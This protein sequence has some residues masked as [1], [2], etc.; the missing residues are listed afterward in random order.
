MNIVSL[1]LSFRS[2][3]IV[4]VVS[5]VAIASTLVTTQSS[6]YGFSGNGSGTEGDPYVITT[7]SEYAEIADD[8]TAAYLLA[9]SLDCSG[10]GEKAY[11]DQGSFFT[12]IFDGGNNSL[13]LNMNYGLGDFQG[14]FRRV[15]EAQIRNVSI[16]G[17]L[18]NG[19][20]SVGGLAGVMSN[21]VV[22]N[23]NVSVN[24]TGGRF[25]G[26]L[27]GYSSD[28]SYNDVTFTGTISS[29]EIN[30]GGLIGNSNE[31][32]I[33]NSQVDASITAA[34]SVGG[35]TGYS[36][37]STFENSHSTGSVSGVTGVGGISGEHLCGGSFTDVYS[38]SDV[39]GTG[40]R[41]GGLVGFDGCEGPGATYT[42]TYSTGAVEGLDNVG[43]LVGFAGYS[44]VIESYSSSDVVG[45]SNVGG[46]LGIGYGFFEGYGIVSE[47]FSTGDVTGAENAGG[48]VGNAEGLVIENSYS[49]SS[50]F[51]VDG[52]GGLIGLFRGGDGMLTN[53]Y[54]TGQTEADNSN[55][56]GLIADWNDVPTI[57]QSFWD[58][59]TTTQ[60]GSDGGEGKTTAEMKTQSTFTD[61][62]W[63]FESVWGITPNLNNGYPCLKWFSEDCV[64]EVGEAESGDSDGISDEVE[65]AAPNGGDANDDGIP[66]SEQGFVASFVNPI[67]GQYVSLAVDENCAISSPS[68]E[69][70]SVDDVDVGFVYPIGLMNFTVDCADPGY[71]ATV[72]QYFYNLNNDDFV[73]RKFNPTTKAYFTI[74][75]AVVSQVE[76]D[77]LQVVKSTFQITDGSALDADGIENGIIVD[78]A[79]LGQIVVGAPRTGTGGTAN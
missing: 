25:N 63:D 15:D 5:L 37:A 47:S 26:G 8:L 66:D 6:S 61:A 72:T 52:A 2:F 62:S 12:G 4:A 75:G 69:E 77:G 79:G 17:T 68:M 7:C 11:T 21:S 76:I 78:P 51:S 67:T 22:E 31:D 43:G 44:Q 53:S 35:F 20:W 42:N 45:D 29:E 58:T 50:V 30:I 60:A 40:N 56:G 28:S 34:D 16:S 3:V 55:V 9:N 18:P 1:K 70:E 41:V 32:T 54:A 71:T 73:A 48:L 59:Q 13:I 33:T 24:F 64:I 39:T 57:T 36:Y 46:L 27:V 38:E 23:V 74:E 65:D 10:T 14:M 49:R 19:A